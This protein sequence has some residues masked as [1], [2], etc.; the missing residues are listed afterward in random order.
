LLGKE[1]FA[2][3]FLSSARHSAK[4]ETKKNPKKIE[5]KISGEAATG[6]HPPVSVEV[7]SRGIFCAKFTANV[8]SGI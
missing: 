6:Q 3:C 8:T 7:L 2:E 4:L 5:K 1:L